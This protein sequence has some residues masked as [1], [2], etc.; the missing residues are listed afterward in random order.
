MNSNDAP[1]A[2]NRATIELEAL[3][4][5]LSFFPLSCVTGEG[6]EM[7]IS[8]L[9]ECLPTKAGARVANG[10]EPARSPVTK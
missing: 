8:W 5:G 7:W 2:Q 6:V 4:P 9:K 10:K 1:A 3:N